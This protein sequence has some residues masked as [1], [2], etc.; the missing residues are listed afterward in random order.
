MLF[1]DSSQWHA[2]ALSTP[3]RT[4]EDWM[5]LWQRDTSVLSHGQTGS[6][7]SCY[8]TLYFGTKSWHNLLFWFCSRLV[9]IVALFVISSCFVLTVLVVVCCFCPKCL[10]YDACRV[11]YTR[12]EII[13]YCKL[14][15]NPHFL[16]VP[17]STTFNV[18]SL[19]VCFFQLRKKRWL[20][21]LQCPMKTR[22]KNQVTAL[23]PLKSNP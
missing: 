18:T 12:G 20:W 11:K 6:N 8:H 13:A 19:F 5:L 1:D 17:C 15:P 21:I 14:F 2:T 10:L 9:M 7:V 23:K 3:W 16:S 22:L 4:R